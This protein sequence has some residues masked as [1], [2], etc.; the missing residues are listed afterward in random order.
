M[1]KAIEKLRLDL[2]DNIV[3]G[4]NSIEALTIASG[5]WAAAG[6]SGMGV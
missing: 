2:E 4:C 6:C 1:T 5:E 3:S